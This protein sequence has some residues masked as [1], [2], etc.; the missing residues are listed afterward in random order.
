MEHYISPDK[1]LRL[2]APPGTLVVVIPYDELRQY[3]MLLSAIRY[4]DKA[5]EYERTRIIVEIEMVLMA[6]YPPPDYTQ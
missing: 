5:R 4:P 2:E 3:Q 6:N 1:F